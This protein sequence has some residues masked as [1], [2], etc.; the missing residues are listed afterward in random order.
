MLMTAIFA[1]PDEAI[2]MN[3]LGNLLFCGPSLSLPR[4]G[5]RKTGGG[6]IKV[7]TEGLGYF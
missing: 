6:T 4:F 7:I 1:H 3:D 5:Q 2:G